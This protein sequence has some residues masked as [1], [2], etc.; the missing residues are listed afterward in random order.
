MRARDVDRFGGEEVRIE[1]VSGDR[2]TG[3]ISLAHC[4]FDPKEEI[5]W[6]NAEVTFYISFRCGLSRREAAI[7]IPI[8]AI[9]NIELVRDLT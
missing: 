9:S 4:V 6:K 8:K 3:V 7:H 1:L 5:K 2:L